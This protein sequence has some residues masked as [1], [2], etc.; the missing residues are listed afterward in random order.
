MSQLTLLDVTLRD[1]GNRVNFHFSDDALA[2]ILKPLEHSGVDLVEIGYRNG[3]I[4]PVADIGR[5]GLCDASYIS[6]CRGLVPTRK[7]AVMAHPQNLK[8]ADIQELKA[9]GVS[10]LRLCVSRGKV[11]LIRPVIEWCKVEDLAVSIN[12]IHASQYSEQEMDEV[13]EVAASQLPDM[14]YF[15]DSNGSLTPPR[16]QNI[17][18]KYVARYDI[19]FG[20]HAHDNIG[21]AQANALSALEAGASYI[22]AS[23]AGM[24]KGIG[25]LRTEFFIAYLEAIKQSNYT[26]LPLLKASNFIRKQFST[27]ALGIDM[28]EFTRGI[29]DLSTAEMSALAKKACA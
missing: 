8:P 19:A 20:F 15:A 7:L 2:S 10:L 24:G 18:Q 28:D 17:Y 6:L 4:R 9:L 27:D 5:A 3:A 1:G 29:Y 23:L 16:V 13:V 12:F 25:N 21:L 22:D 26:L 11:N 14:I